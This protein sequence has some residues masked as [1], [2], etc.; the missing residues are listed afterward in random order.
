MKLRVPCVVACGVA[1]LGS[2]VTVVKISYCQRKGGVGMRGEGSER[3]GTGEGVL[4]GILES[5]VSVRCLLESTSVCLW[6]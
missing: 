6:V 2:P 4:Q 1:G 3:D 5:L